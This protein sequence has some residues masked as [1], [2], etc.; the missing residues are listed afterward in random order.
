MPSTV[1]V[2]YFAAARTAVNI[3]SEI[4][5]LPS[6]P[7]RLSSLGDLLIAR[8]AQTTLAKVLTISAW[9]VNQTMVNSDELESYYLEGGEE[10]A[11]IPPVSGG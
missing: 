6:T 5:E 2:L 9:S 1:K 10:I 3:S 11:P 7:F 4:V 8:H